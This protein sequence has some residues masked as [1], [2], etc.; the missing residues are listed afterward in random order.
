MPIATNYQKYSIVSDVYTVYNRK[1]VDIDC[2]GV[3]KTV[4]F[5][6][7]DE[8][9]IMH[10]KQLKDQLGFE[11]GCISLLICDNE[12]IFQQWLEQHAK[13]SKVFGWYIEGQE[14]NNLPE[15]L[16]STPLRWDEISFEN[17]VLPTD[18]IDMIVAKKRHHFQL[19]NVRYTA[20]DVGK[21]ILDI[22]VCIGSF[23]IYTRF[24]PT[25]IYSF[26]AN[27]NQGY[28]WL[29]TSSQNIK[30]GESY[31]LTGVIKAVQPSKVV[32]TRCKIK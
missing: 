4:R 24:G 26:I 18:E 22:V 2:G 6:D 16:T 23:P 5:Y 3:V 9:N 30:I 10:P 8:W 13:Y 7:D 17:E 28:E 12:T 19:Q 29:T 20:D 25:T 27:D 14:T 31:Q 32:L 11:S 21:S 15:G 1:Y